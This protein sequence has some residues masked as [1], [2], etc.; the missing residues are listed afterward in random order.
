MQPF[1][2]CRALLLVVVV[3][4]RCVSLELSDEEWCRNFGAS[5]GEEDL[6]EDRA[7]YLEKGLHLEWPMSL[8]RE[9]PLTE[10]PEGAITSS[11]R[12]DG[13]GIQ[14]MLMAGVFAR[15]FVLNVPYCHSEWNLV[16]HVCDEDPL[17]PQKDLRSEDPRVA[18]DLFHF[19]GGH[20]LGPPAKA[21]TTRVGLG[22]FKWWE[23]FK[24]GLYHPESL[25]RLRDA[26]WMLPKPPLTFF[27]KD[28]FNVAVH[29]RRGDV[30]ER[31]FEDN[32][33]YS[34]CLSHLVPLLQNR[35]KDLTL[36]V[37]I[38]SE[39]PPLNETVEDAFGTIRIQHH[40]QS[41]TPHL[42]LSTPLAETFHHMVTADA[43]VTAS[44]AFSTS[45]AMLSQGRTYNLAGDKTQEGRSRDCLEAKI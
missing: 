10:C 8:I 44:S 31:R 14:Y 27:S 39:R 38:F 17:T 20:L 25:A 13:L 26:Y 41:W 43:L 37:H 22:D 6:S 28:H 3:R 42:H 5:C 29:V 23:D 7:S 34:E 30:P 35:Y 12:K 16:A 15:S 21:N 36:Q 32:D 4:V 19:V 11:V 33:R 1:F 40:N 9:E 18:K 45:A 2:F 24:E